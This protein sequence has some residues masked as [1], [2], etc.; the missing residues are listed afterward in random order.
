MNKYFNILLCGLL[1]FIGCEDE[2]AEDNDSHKD[3]VQLK[4][5]GYT[6]YSNTYHGYVYYKESRPSVPDRWSLSTWDND[7]DDQ[8]YY[9][10][11]EIELFQSEGYFNYRLSS[12]PNVTYTRIMNP[13][14]VTYTYSWA[15]EEE[16]FIFMP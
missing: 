5:I 4:W 12:E 10:C 16:A 11:V 7:N 9:K 3:D 8:E 6:Y 15:W 14:N 1:V 13:E 2:K